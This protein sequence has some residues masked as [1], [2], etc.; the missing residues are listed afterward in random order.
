MLETI[1]KFLKNR[2]VVS[3]ILSICIFQLVSGL[4]VPRF[5]NEEREIRI[6]ATGRKNAQSEGNGV[7]IQKISLDGKNKVLPVDFFTITS[8]EIGEGGILTWN[9]FKNRSNVISAKAKFRT[10]EIGLTREGYSGIAKVYVDDT[11]MKE[12]DLYSNRSEIVYV[13]IDGINNGSTMIYI[14]KSVV[15]FTL[16]FLI[17]YILSYFF[18]K[19]VEPSKVGIIF[20]VSLGFIA[21]LIYVVVYST[22][23]QFLKTVT[24]SISIFILIYVVG[25]RFI[26]MDYWY[27]VILD[28]HKKLM[29]ALLILVCILIPIFNTI[30]SSKII[31]EEVKNS[32]EN[33]TSIPLVSG[34]S[35]KQN[36]NMVG[37]VKKMHINIENRDDNEGSFIIRAVQ[38]KKKIEWNLQGVDCNNKDSIELD[39]TDLS[40]GEF[41][42]YIDTSYTDADKSVKVL[43]SN[44]T[45]F[46]KLEEN[47]SII[48]DKNLCMSLDVSKENVYYIPQMTAFIFMSIVLLLAVVNVTRCKQNDK[49]TFIFYKKYYFFVRC[50]A[51]S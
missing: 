28:K 29:F 26:D 5:K 51:C 6:E 37:K 38:D 50:T 36:I 48:S 3:I 19:K 46:G 24:M 49:L 44:D 32:T 4:I 11:L 18:Q 25:T 31:N 42:L 12:V 7:Q 30:N 34:S 23:L 39:L 20:S 40:Q 10:L 1:K 45:R 13:D 27:R 16:L 22:N 47:N 33:T 21:S 8:W 9:P 35:L 17:N 15:L 43:S 41:F 14:L 2:V